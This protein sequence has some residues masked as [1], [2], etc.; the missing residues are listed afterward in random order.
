MITKEDLQI[1][2]P[3]TWPELKFLEERI[4][5]LLQER[6]E[7]LNRIASFERQI[8]TNEEFQDDLIEKRDEALRRGDAYREIAIKAKEDGE[9]SCIKVYLRSEE[10]KVDKEAA[11]ILEREAKSKEGK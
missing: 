3:N 11:K 2:F 9:C 10:E 1:P 8:K 6:D 7:A 5:Q 4:K